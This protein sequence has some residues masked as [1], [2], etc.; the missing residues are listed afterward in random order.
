MLAIVHTDNA[1][2]VARAWRRN[3]TPSILAMAHADAESVPLRADAPCAKREPFAS[4]LR[5]R[6]VH[7]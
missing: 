4:T 1:A 6:A 3:S 2:T 7:G 5:E